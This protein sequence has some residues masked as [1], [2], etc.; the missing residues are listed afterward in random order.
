MLISKILNVI[1][2]RNL[3]FIMR[4]KASVPNVFQYACKR[5]EIKKKKKTR[6]LIKISS[7]VNA[8]HRNSITACQTLG[9]WELYVY[10]LGIKIFI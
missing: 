10:T 7:L 2:Q 8:N 6:K 5:S 9:F 4:S 3:C 1:F